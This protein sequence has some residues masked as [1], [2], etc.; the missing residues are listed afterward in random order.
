[1]PDWWETVGQT[2][3]VAG[4]SLGFIWSVIGVAQRR[5][6]YLQA[7]VRPSMQF[8]WMIAKLIATSSYLALLVAVGLMAAEGAIASSLAWF[9][10]GLAAA[11][12]GSAM[13][14]S[15][16][17]PPPCSVPDEI[18]PPRVSEFRRAS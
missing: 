6:A 17:Q 9:L 12:F 1:M 5:R 7:G 4:V 11:A 3:V 13:W 18:L 10:V 16:I 8:V 2:S 15:S 14:F